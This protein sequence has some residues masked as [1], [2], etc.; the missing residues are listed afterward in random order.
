MLSIRPTGFSGPKISF[1]LRYKVLI[2]CW[3]DSY[4]NP[5]FN[6][7]QLCPYHERY[8]ESMAPPNTNISSTIADCTGSSPGNLPSHRGG[9]MSSVNYKP[10]RAR[11]GPIPAPCA[12]NNLRKRTANEILGLSRQSA[13]RGVRSLDSEI[14]AYLLNTHLATGISNALAYW[15]VGI[16]IYMT[17]G[18]SYIIIFRRINSGTQLCFLQHLIT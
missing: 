10:I 6:L 12:A 13:A 16:I 3:L 14:A 7:N 15:Q 18:H 11:S 9:H 5:D 1:F 4:T 8:L 17:T 2:C